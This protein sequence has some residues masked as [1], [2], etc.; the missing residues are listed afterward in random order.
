MQIHT[1]TLSTGQSLVIDTS[2]GVY[3]F[4]F[5]LNT[6]SSGTLLGDVIINGVSSSAVTLASGGATITANT[7]TSPLTGITL[8]CTGG[9]IDVILTVFI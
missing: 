1:R 7:P 6:S 9:T 3:G 4:S 5:N 8:T 2:M